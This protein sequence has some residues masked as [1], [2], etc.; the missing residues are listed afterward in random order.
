MYLVH[1]LCIQSGHFYAGQVLVLERLC[2]PPVPYRLVLLV[3]H[4]HHR[5]QSLAVVGRYQTVDVAE[6]YDRTYLLVFLDS[7]T[8]QGF[9]LVRHVL[10]LNLHAQSSAHSH[11]DAVFHRSGAEHGV[12]GSCRD[13]ACHGDG[14]EEIARSPLHV[15][16]LQGIRVVRHPELVEVWQ[17]APVGSSA[18]RRT[19]LYGDV[20]ILGADALA[21]LLEATVIFYVQVTLVAHGQIL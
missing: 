7:L 5:G 14:W 6:L 17:H 15:D 18:T 16:A 13:V 1:T 12:V 11:V 9:L 19:S 2:L 8:A 20:R 3:C 4:I 10:G 21:H